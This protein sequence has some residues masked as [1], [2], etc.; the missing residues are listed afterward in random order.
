[1]LGRR[2]KNS[3]SGMILRLDLPC[4][5]IKSVYQDHGRKTTCG[6]VLAALLAAEPLV[7]G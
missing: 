2:T 4:G 6:S 7:L 3:S 5:L 1:M